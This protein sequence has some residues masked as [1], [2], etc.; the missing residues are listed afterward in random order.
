MTR[1]TGYGS[2]VEAGG[3]AGGGG[4]GG[5]AATG[6]GEGGEGGGGGGLGGSIALMATQLG[7]ARLNVGRATAWAAERMDTEG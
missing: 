5:E 1:S 2:L 7:L 6:G 4:R 3:E